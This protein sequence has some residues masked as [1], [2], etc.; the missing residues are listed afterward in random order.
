MGLQ[1]VNIM[2]CELGRCLKLKRSELLN[3]ST[4]FKN[5]SFKGVETS[6]VEK[7]RVRL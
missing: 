1:E 5:K 6:V 7:G 3:H 4:E 2:N